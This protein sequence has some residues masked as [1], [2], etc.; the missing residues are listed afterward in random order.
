MEEKDPCVAVG[1]VVLLRDRDA[2]RNVWPLARVREVL[3][4]EDSLVRSVIL[5]V[6][7]AGS[8][9]SL[10]KRCISDLVLL[11]PSGSHRC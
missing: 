5:H 11:L 6:P 3:A 1:D 9:G 4:S 2:P 7:S 8:T 10:L